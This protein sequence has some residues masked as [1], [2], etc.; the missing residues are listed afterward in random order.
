MRTPA[1]T[2]A[3]RASANE[4]TSTSSNVCPPYLACCPTVSCSSLTE[5]KLLDAASPTAT[6]ITPMC[7]I[8]PPLVRPNEAPPTLS[9]R[10]EHDLS[11]GRAASEA[12]EPERDRREAPRPEDDRQRQRRH[13]DD[14][15][16]NSRCDSSSML[17]LRHG[18]T[19]AMPMMNSST[20][21]IGLVMVSK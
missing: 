6:T 2:P 14:A 16:Q 7:T 15:G 1:R 5:L 21:P 11:S 12:G 9:T 19:G 18:S 10:G 3:E 4:V 13:T 20:R 8:I 17:A